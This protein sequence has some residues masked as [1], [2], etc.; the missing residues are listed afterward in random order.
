MTGKSTW[1][2]LAR[3]FAQT[4]GGRRNPLSGK[5]SGKPGDNIHPEFLAECK[6][7]KRIAIWN[8]FK[9]IEEESEDVDKIPMLVLKQKQE[10]GELVCLKMEDL[11]EIVKDEYLYKYQPRKQEHEEFQER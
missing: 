11:Q 1:K 3:K 9:E 8:W 10:Q 6:Y 2:R 5:S 7:R 4:F